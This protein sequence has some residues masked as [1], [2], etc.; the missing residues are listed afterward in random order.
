MLAGGIHSERN[1]KMRW[2]G[3]QEMGAGLCKAEEG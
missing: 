2:G 1:T 3:G